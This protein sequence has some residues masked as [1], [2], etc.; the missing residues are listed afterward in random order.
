VRLPRALRHARLNAAAR[1][2]PLTTFNRGFNAPSQWGLP[3]ALRGNG[4]L[5]GDYTAHVDAIEQAARNS[6]TRRRRENI[7]CTRERLTY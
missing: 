6:D 5:V 7:L 4:R 3:D 2:D 1:V